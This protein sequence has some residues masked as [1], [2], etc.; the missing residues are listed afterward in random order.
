MRLP[1]RLESAELELQIFLLV[2]ELL[3]A[4]RE[5]NVRV[6]QSAVLFIELVI[7]VVFHRHSTRHRV[8]HH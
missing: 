2:Q 3:E 6:V 4:I 1:I 7:L 5:D 8:F